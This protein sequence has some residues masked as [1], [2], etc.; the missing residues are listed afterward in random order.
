MNQRT[1]NPRKV[2]FIRAAGIIFASSLLLSACNSND[3]DGR[4]TLPQQFRLSQSR[5]STFFEVR[6]GRIAI[7]QNDGNVVLTDQTG[8]KTVA[9]TDDAGAAVLQ[10]RS[11]SVSTRYVLPLWSPDAANLALLELRAAQP[12]TSQVRFDGALGVFVEAQPGSVMAEQTQAGIAR[13]DMLETERFGFEPR[14]VTIEFGGRHVSS[15]LY[16]VVPDGPGPLKEVWYSEDRVEY[17]DWSPRGNELALLTRGEEQ[18]TVTVVGTNGGERRSI[19]KGSELRW[20]WKPDGASLLLRTDAGLSVRNAATGE[21]EVMLPETDSTAMPQYAPDGSAMVVA[22]VRDGETTLSLADAAGVVQRD[23]ATV[24]GDVRFV[25]SPKSDAVAFVTQEDGRAVG[26]LRIVAAA[27]GDA[28]LLS[29]TPVVGFFWSPDGTHIAAFSP[30]DMSAL[31]DG[32]ETPS[33]VSESS[34]NPMVVQTIDVAQG[35][36]SVRRLI[37]VEPSFRFLA[38]LADFDRYAHSLTIWSPNSRRLVVPF[39]VGVGEGG[40]ADYIVETE[41]SGSIW[42]RVLGEGSLAAWSPR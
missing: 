6:S 7:V 39:T 9:L 21:S 3:S 16:T 40:S 27:G 2:R 35:V 8:E 19:V 38:L 42:P 23:L 13:R 26:P 28:R 24:R 37:Y 25:W 14:R 34:T 10:D 36:S 22:R 5:L 41:A 32:D 1:V 29:A 15:A 30:L 17:A 12:F 33:A 4:V 11:G 20:D 31:V 18:D